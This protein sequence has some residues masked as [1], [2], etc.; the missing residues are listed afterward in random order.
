VQAE[1]PSRYTELVEVGQGGMAVVYRARDSTLGRTVAV[2][3]LHPHLLAEVESK[4]RLQREAQ[5]VAKLQHDNIVQI[6]D[7]SGADSKTSFIVTEFIEGQTLKQ[8]MGDGYLPYPEL[9]ALIVI[10]VGHAVAHAHG[11]GI[12][13]R[14][15]K[16]EN[17]MVRRD[18]V[19]KL[20]DFGV[21][22]VM[23]LERMTVTGQLIGSPAYM[24]PELIEGK[25][26]DFR[27]DVFAVGTMLYQLCTGKLPFSGRNPHEVF[28]RITDGRYPSPRSV[29]T[30]ISIALERVIGKTL[31]RKPDDRYPTMGALIADLNLLVTEA[32][33]LDPRADLQRYFL[34][35]A[36]ETIR[37]RKSM[38]GALVESGRRAR[39]ERRIARALECWNR[40]LALI[41]DDPE[42]ARE[43]RRIE[44]G[45]R[46]RVTLASLGMLGVMILGV[47]GV[48]RGIGG[49]SALVAPALPGAADVTESL[50]GK[51]VQTPSIPGSTTP[52]PQPRPRLVGK[53]TPRLP[54]STGLAGTVA[55]PAAIPAVQQPAQ[56]VSRVFELSVTPQNAEVWLDDRRMFDWGPGHT[57]LSIPWDG[58]H[59][60]ELRNDCCYPARRQVGPGLTPEG[61]QSIRVR[62]NPK[63]AQLTVSLEPSSPGATVLLAEVGGKWKTT[64]AVGR[65]VT[66][67]FDPEGEFVKS[68]SA[69]VFSGESPVATQT[70]TVRAGENRTEK[71][72]VSR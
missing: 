28:K 13:H 62:L 2:K 22:Q 26:V 37:L 27:T 58:P 61:D 54:R 34:D 46:L 47:Y 24:A 31:A 30:A 1:L 56:A 72:P 5:A 42:V 68:L 11:M 6:Y 64:M 36:G 12:L 49:P 59:K 20:M 8:L 39:R 50:N 63:P 9:A 7:Y 4:A 18:G 67:P 29:N 21:A 43:I 41:P 17:V 55:T 69:T 35:E 15:I 48:I 33:F 19:L 10:E 44:G 32:G 40:A 38:H 70:F 23:D 16:P 71:V 51:R 57:S 52:S 25:P 14:D 66:V 53:P 3:V 45:R 60:V 65:M